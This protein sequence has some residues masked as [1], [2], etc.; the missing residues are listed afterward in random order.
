F[1]NQNITGLYAACFS[2]PFALMNIHFLYRFWAIRYPHLINLFSKKK[3]ITLITMYP[4]IEFIIWF[5]LMTKGTEGDGPSVEKDLATAEVLKRYGVD[6]SEG[7]IVLSYW[8][9]NEFHLK[10]FLTL[11]SIDTILVVSLLVATGQ[12]ATHFISNTFVPF[13]FVYTPYFFVFNL[14]FFH[15]PGY[16]ID[17]FCCTFVSS[18]PA[19]DAIIMILLMKDYR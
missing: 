12:Y 15:L 13:V 1:L 7:W 6:M 4:V 10:L 5:F 16:F 3:F 9:N 17:D 8:E 2:L 14:P 18:F 11:M 19:W